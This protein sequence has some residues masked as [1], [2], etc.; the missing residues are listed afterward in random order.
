MADLDARLEL[1]VDEA[2]SGI[3]RIDDALG[4]AVTNFKVAL[5][6]ALNLLS[7][8]AIEDVDASN[9]T[10]AIDQ[11]VGAA[12][13]SPVIEADAGGVT[14][15][16]DEAVAGADTTAEVTG[17]AEQLTLAIDDAVSAADTTV[18][19]EVAAEAITLA[20]D[21]A[22]TAADTTVEVEADT[23]QAEAEI[24]GLGDTASQAA[25]GLDSF[26]EAGGKAAGSMDLLGPAAGFAAGNLD[27]AAGAAG[28][29][30]PQAAAA[31]GAVTGLAA[32]GK[33]LFDNALAQQTALERLNRTFGETADDVQQI[34][35]GGLN[36]DISS[37]AL[38]T[39]G[40]DE[41]LQ[42]FA[43]TFGQL[44]IDS[45]KAAG[46]VANTVDQ[47]IALS[48]RAAVL[49]P[50]LGTSDEIVGRLSNGLAR[51]GRFLA[52]YGIS[53]TAAEI[54][55]RALA[56]T[57]KKSADQLT[58][59]E[60]SAAGAA[61]ATE[62]L[63][64][65]L[66]RDINEGAKADAIQVLSLKTAID[67]ATEAAG[68]EIVGPIVDDM[69]ELLPVAE[70][71]AHLLGVTLKVALEALG[72]SLKLVGEGAELL[73]GPLEALAS[74]EEVVTSL[75]AVVNPAAG[76]FDLF[77]SGG[78][79]T[80][81]LVDSLNEA[82][83]GFEDLATPV[84]QTAQAMATATL[85]AEGMDVALNRV[86]LTTQDLVAAA[87]DGKAGVE[88]L[89][90]R[91]AAA[92]K[93]SGEFADDSD[94][95]LDA[96]QK[97]ADAFQRNARAALDHLSAT[98]QLDAAQVANLESTTQ[99]ASGNTNYLAVLRQLAPAAAAKAEADTK[100]VDPATDLAEAAERG[101]EAQAKL[102]AETA[103]AANKIL[104]N[105]VRTGSL[106]QAQRDAAVAVNTNNEGVT[107]YIALLKAID[108]A[109]A[110]QAERQG[111]VNAGLGDT[112]TAY[113]VAADAADLYKTKVD[114]LLG[115]LI[116]SSEA[117]LRYIE[118][119][120]KTRETLT[121]NAGAIDL[122]TK[123][124]QEDAHAINDLVGSISNHVES[125]I[126]EGAS[127]GDINKAR[128]EGVAALQALERQYPQLKP[129]IDPYIAAIQ[130]IP[131]DRG[132]VVHADNVPDANAKIESVK[133]NAQ[134]LV[135]RFGVTNLK[136]NADASQA[137]GEIQ[138]V[139][140]VYTTVKAA[141]ERAP[142]RIGADVI[143]DAPPGFNVGI[144]NQ[145][146][147]PFRAG[148]VMTIN[149]LGIEPVVFGSPGYVVS[150]AEAVAAVERAAGSGGALDADKLL[151]GLER[152]VSSQRPLHVHEVAQDTEAT[153]F[154][155]AARLGEL[156]SR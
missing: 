44:G 147:G 122:H 121:K 78:E 37:L 84:D 97:L 48:T 117:E 83:A 125:L 20:I 77:S 105:L 116:A 100:G 152:F 66:G 87:S 33:I 108:P 75:S 129:V 68:K 154:A 119:L 53:L 2:L 54:N 151:A 135:N 25:G 131:P 115:R 120:D 47:I 30:G 150:H 6:D 9:V 143:V 146:G 148:Q 39:G 81:K 144:K 8:V 138:G 14:A 76:L 88:A 41:G 91:L 4:S 58:V 38:R 93:T 42:N 141:L 40:A 80:D 103:N 19:P 136:V 71:A 29:L 35:I 27:E 26:G 86:G 61:L 17:E 1:G 145:A 63:G 90:D 50:T 85:E 149:E 13:T 89:R 22:I 49:N 134:D 104:D 12:D 51:G 155:L 82:G 109:L 113:E 45:G 140:V 99:L 60:K 142:I 5:A 32:A 73:A 130:S 23:T 110:D 98:G 28:A 128:G 64:N 24:S 111:E 31:A 94:R 127:Q 67:E 56:D 96:T 59:Y 69:Q 101:A 139:S 11:A 126:R 70:Q 62:R 34:D 156:A 112:R 43:A 137:V 21:D 95:V 107:D 57:G 15:S 92:G 133:L 123:A 10:T 52:Q 72:P 7:G 18:T 153:A 36:E 118:T 114:Q 55:A 102:G 74:S 106:T 46:E 16:I 124:G 79:E 65:Q 132:T 3:D